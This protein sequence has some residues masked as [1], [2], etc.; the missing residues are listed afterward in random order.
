M[1]WMIH[2]TKTHHLAEQLQETAQ[3]PSKQCIVIFN[4][5][6]H[7]IHCLCGAEWYDDHCTYLNQTELTLPCTTLYEMALR[8]LLDAVLQIPAVDVYVF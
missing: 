4:T 8:V 5:G 2:Q 1:L 6:M 7:D 3:L